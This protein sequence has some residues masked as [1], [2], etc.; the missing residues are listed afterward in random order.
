MKPLLLLLS[1][2]F[3]AWSSAHA[4]IKEVVYDGQEIYI[5]TLKDH[6][7][8]VIF[9]EVIKGVVRG[10]G[11][12][13]YVIERRGSNPKILELMPAGS[14]PAEVTVSGVSNE[15]YVLRFLQGNGPEDF[16]TKV[17]ILPIGQAIKNVDVLTDNLVNQASEKTRK[18]DE[19]TINVK[20]AILPDV[21]IDD[22]PQDIPQHNLQQNTLTKSATNNELKETVTKEEKMEVASDLALPAEL[23]RKV[24]LRGNALPLKVFL[25][26]IGNATGYNVIATPDVEEKK[27]SVSL[28]NIEVWRALKSLLYPLSYG[29]KVSKDDLIISTSETRVYD[30]AIPAVEQSF[31]DLTS[32]ESFTLN[33]NGS[34]GS[35]TSNNNTV[36]QD[37]RVGTKIMLENKSPVLSLW[38][39]LE[40]NIK[41]MVSPTGSFSLNRVSGNIIVTD[42]PGT[43]DRIGELVATINENLRKQENFEIQIIEVALNNQSE[44][45]IDWSAVAKNIASLSNITSV[46][47]FANAGFAGGQLFSLAATGPRSDS[48]KNSGGISLIIKALE[49]Q[50]HIEVISRPNITVSNMIPCILQAGTN[51][52]YISGSGQIFNNNV[53]STGVQTSQVSEGLTL[54]IVAKIGDKNKDTILNLS[55]SVTTIDSINNITSGNVTI[56]T[57]QVSNKSITTNVGVK[58]GKSLIIGGLI[59]TTNKNSNQ[60]IPVLSRIP[61]FGGA[62]KYKAKTNNK[63][64]LVIVITP[65]KAS[66]NQ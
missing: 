12:D 26:T 16:Y 39:D 10:Y 65:K 24:T 64:E 15:E 21:L 7:T 8:T 30:V 43:L 18:E 42:M 61:F 20:K 47:N 4:S 45:G 6:K 62:F 32:N 2:V 56:Q 19:K 22:K 58:E 27:V 53:V 44:M 28:E 13:S 36:S 48:G 34:G 66:H 25:R 51:K 29:F 9:P 59:S 63:S 11:A 54:R 49:Q 1:L 35:A 60:G 33:Q 52:T 23:N 14:E 41:M 37:V 5:R 40:N 46:T 38:N 3:V 57:P 55:A 31:S 50:G 17:E